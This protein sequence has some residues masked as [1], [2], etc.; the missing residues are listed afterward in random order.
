[1]SQ[2]GEV[3]QWASHTPALL[4]ALVSTVGPVLECGVGFNSTP[5]LHSVCGAMGRPLY[6]LDGSREWLDKFAGL[7]SDIHTLVHVSDWNNPP[8]YQGCQYGVAFVDHDCEPRGDI[9]PLL[10]DK[11][12]VIVMH[13]SECHYCGYGK[14]LGLFDWTYTHKNTSAWTTLAG[15]GAAPPWLEF[16]VP[17]AATLPIPYRG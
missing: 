8:I 5:L 7:A 16:L 9:L 15:I 6:S 10:R 1:M 13:D 17:G 3:N 2:E 12:D 4:T 14:H 11:A